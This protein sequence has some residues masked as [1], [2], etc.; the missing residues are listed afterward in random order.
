MT[1]ALAHR[2][3]DGSG[4]WST[5]PAL[6]GQSAAYIEAQLAGWS[7]GERRGD[8][9]GLMTAIAKRLSAKDRKSV[10]AYYASLPSAS[11]ATVPRAGARR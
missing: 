11:W 7:D 4:V 5:S 3:P 6:A 1:A 2:G 9:L 10:A 8:P